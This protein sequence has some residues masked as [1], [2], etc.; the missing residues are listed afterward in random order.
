MK[1]LVLL[2]VALTVTAAM[3]CGSSDPL[4]V[5]PLPSP[6]QHT[7]SFVGYVYD[8]VSGARLDGYSISVLVENEVVEGVVTEGR[9][10]VGDTTVWQDFTV[11]IEASGY[12]AFESHNA[13]VG[14]PAEFAG[15]DDIGEI[16][17]HQ[18][19]HFDAYLFPD[20]LSA[21]AVTL[22]IETD[23]PGLEP[24]G[25]LR[26]RPTS[27]SILAD[28]GLETP[29]GVDDQ[30]WFNDQDLQGDTI[31]NE[32]S[33]GSLD[34]AA[35]DLVYGVTYRVDIYDVAGFQPL[36]SS[37]RAGID[38][39]KTFTLAEEVQEPLKVVSSDH[40]SCEAPDAVDASNAAVVSIQ[41]NKAV[42]F[43]ESQ[44]IGGDA[45][46]IDDGLSIASPNLDGDEVTNALFGDESPSTQLRGVSLAID[47][48][49]LQLSWNAATGL[50]TSDPDD[51]ID[52]V[53]YAGLSNISVQ[54][55]GTPS[56][57]TTIAAL[58]GTSSIVCD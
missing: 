20:D 36:E 58:I 9:Y 24:S 5:P 30:L 23:V 19:F 55:I 35:G 45:E 26:L 32:F 31:T 56:S 53:T 18:T 2:L 38:S 22:T 7:A 25:T 6:V 34:I 43:G 37:F 16:G 46:A 48:N 42:E 10:V 52:L 39:D 1:R 21:P 4:A 17:T 44:Y 13:S 15:S 49:T 51:P 41:L 8:G 3:G 47:G 27:P 50:E 57:K 12:R 40:T 11:T 29:A 54:R 28:E 14:L 33:G